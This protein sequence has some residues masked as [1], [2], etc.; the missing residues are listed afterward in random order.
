MSLNVCYLNRL[1]VQSIDLS[2]FIPCTLCSRTQDLEDLRGLL[3]LHLTK[4]VYFFP[5]IETNPNKYNNSRRDSKC[6]FNLVK[7]YVLSVLSAP[8]AQEVG[9]TVVGAQ[10]TFL[11]WSE[12]P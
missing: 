6:Y 7:G 4:L 10:V 8:T 11:A 3:W 12:R 1:S 2:S 5:P 9:G